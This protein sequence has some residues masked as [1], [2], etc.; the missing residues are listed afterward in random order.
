MVAGGG[1]CD[2]G[3]MTRIRGVDFTSVPRR[4]KPITLAEAQLDGEVLRVDEVL[5]LASFIEFEDA[6][7]EEGPWVAA[8]DFPFGLPLRF[9]DNVE[10]PRSSWIDYVEHVR[11]MGKV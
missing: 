7:A 4:G 8:I 3:G 11:S 5:P 6:L 9:L 10:W 2:D 1:A